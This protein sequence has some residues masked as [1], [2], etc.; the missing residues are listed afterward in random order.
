LQGQVRA[1]QQ[2]FD[3][4]E[5]N[6]FGKIVKMKLS[7]YQKVKRNVTTNKITDSKSQVSLM[8]V[9]FSNVVKW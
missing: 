1:E 5:E 8:F 3:I 2:D 6:D 4:Y 7:D 9:S